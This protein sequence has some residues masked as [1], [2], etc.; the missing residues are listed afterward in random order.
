MSSN[1]NYGIVM[2]KRS[3]LEVWLVV[4][5]LGREVASTWSFE[6][7]KWKVIELQRSVR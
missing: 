6:G 7:A 2:R 4:D 1:A 3:G 5:S